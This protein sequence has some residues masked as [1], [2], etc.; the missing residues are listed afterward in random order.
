M[1]FD[2][3]KIFGG[4]TVVLLGAGVSNM[5]LAR[6]LMEAGA[7]LIVRDRK[8]MQALGEAGQRLQNMG[9]QMIL[10]ENYLENIKGDFLFRSPGFRPDLPQLLQARDSGCVLT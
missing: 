8:D 6:V 2:F 5:P 10:G 7:R 9:A 1:C 4:K 3:Q